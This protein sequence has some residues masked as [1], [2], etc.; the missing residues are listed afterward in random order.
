MRVGEKFEK[1]I[2]SL[3]N[4]LLFFVHLYLSIVTKTAV[5][6]EQGTIT[7]HKT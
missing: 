7:I 6:Q 1:K 5:E 3:L 4:K 2:F